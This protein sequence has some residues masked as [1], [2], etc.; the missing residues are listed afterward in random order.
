M[1]S[2]NV[3]EGTDANFNTEVIKSSIPVLVD[4][5]ATW[6]GPCKTI[7]PILD[8]LADEYIGKIKIVKVDVDKNNQTP[9]QYGVRSI[10]ALK[11]FKDGK[12]VEEKVGVIP[13]QTLKDMF[14]KHI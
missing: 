5:W 2:K 8:E 1:E 9:T 6:C 11:F 14:T 10:P 3:I 12:M 13:K 7:G 4:F